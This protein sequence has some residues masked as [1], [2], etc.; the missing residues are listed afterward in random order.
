MSYDTA[1]LDALDLVDGA[2]YRSAGRRRQYATDYGTSETDGASPDVV[3]C[4]QSTRDVQSVLSAANTHGV[5]VTPYAAGTSTEGHPVPYAGGITLDMTELDRIIDIR[6]EELQIDVQP[7]IIGE[8][9][10]AAVRSDGLFFPPF[11]SS[12]NMSTV[13]GMI[14]NDASGMQTVK[15]GEVREWIRSLEVVLPDGSVMHPG[16]R[17][18]KTSSGYNLKDLFVGSEG[19]LGVVTEATLEL[20]GL[21]EQIWGGRATFETTDAAAAAVADA[22]TSGVDVATIELMDPLSMDIANAYVD[23]G[24]PAVPTVF[25]EVHANTGIEAEVEFCQT[26]LESHGAEDFQIAA[27]RSQFDQ[28]WESRREIGHALTAYDPDLSMLTVGDIAVPMSAYPD[29]IRFARSMAE[30]HDLLIPC[31]GHAGDGNVHYTILVDME[32]SD[33]VARGREAADR[34][35]SRAITLGGTATGE[36]GIGA[37]KRRYMEEEHGET[38]IAYM[39]RIKDV[40]DPNG[41]MNPGKVIPE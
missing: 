18:R 24:M 29:I 17:A 36:H 26:V 10:N 13:G 41:I 5:P 39:K 12:S 37:R 4:P 33:H 25:F 23:T 35:I 6:P 15:Y 20:S 14:A 19:T 22:V 11:P 8:T 16:T 21:P 28:L 34:I 31:F 30:K 7:G 3:V 27:D 9:V 40:F 38:A 1:F 32:D 2:I